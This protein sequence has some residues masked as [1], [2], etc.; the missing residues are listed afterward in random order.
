M[1]DRLR[2]FHGSLNA[3]LATLL[4]LRPALYFL[5]AYEKAFDYDGENELTIS[6]KIAV[7]K[8]D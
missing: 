2:K 1:L 7:R 5:G 4:F 3:V 6:F 8:E